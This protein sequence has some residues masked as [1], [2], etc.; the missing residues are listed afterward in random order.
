LGTDHRGLVRY[1]DSNDEN[2]DF[3]KK[4]IL[5]K[6]EDVLAVAEAEQGINRLENPL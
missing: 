2:F 3:V 6:L 5:V 4:T 1:Q